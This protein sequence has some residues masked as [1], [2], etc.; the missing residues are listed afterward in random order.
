MGVLVLIAGFVA[1]IG[2]IKV[3]ISIQ[4]SRDATARALLRET[5]E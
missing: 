1:L 4:K 5:N 3:A 2:V